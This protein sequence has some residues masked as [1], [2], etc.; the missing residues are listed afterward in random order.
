MSAAHCDYKGDCS[1]R[2]ENVPI[3][4][5]YVTS[6][7]LSKYFLLMLIVMSTCLRTKVFVFFLYFWFEMWMV[8]THAILCISFSLIRNLFD[9]WIMR[10]RRSGL[11]ALK[12]LRLSSSFFPS[13]HGSWTSSSL[14]QLYA[15]SSLHLCDSVCRYVATIALPIHDHI[16]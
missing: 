14:G 5:G 11:Y 2:K 4:E 3:K 12:R 7:V 16:F 8:K 10:S 15:F 1:S 6:Y 13:Y 9:G